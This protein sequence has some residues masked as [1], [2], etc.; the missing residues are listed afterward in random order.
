[1][2]TESLSDSSVVEFYYRIV[3]EGDVDMFPMLRLVE[4]LITKEYAN[5]FTAST[6]HYTLCIGGRTQDHDTLTVV[7]WPHVL[8]F[9]IRYWSNSD[10]TCQTHQVHAQDAETLIDSLALRLSMAQSST[11]H[12]T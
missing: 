5:F 9:Q 12:P 1:M 2:K 4:R 8:K 10:R 3:D 7:Y 6:S 11:T